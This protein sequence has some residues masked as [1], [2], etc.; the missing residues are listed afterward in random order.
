MLRNGK[1]YPCYL[2]ATIKYFNEKFGT[3]ISEGE[4]SIDI[5]RNNISGIDIINRLKHGFDICKYCTDDEFYLWG[6]ADKDEAVIS[7]W[8]V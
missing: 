5:Y 8:I 3:D 6:R 2:P 7:D 4:S 1:L